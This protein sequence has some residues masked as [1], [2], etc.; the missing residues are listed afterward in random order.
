MMLVPE[1]RLGDSA[2]LCSHFVR[3]RGGAAVPLLQR[4]PWR[5]PGALDLGGAGHSGT[6]DRR[7]Q[8]D[9]DAACR[10]VHLDADRVAISSLQPNDSPP[11]AADSPELARARPGRTP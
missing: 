8:Q 7:P 4:R 5:D 6:A 10:K 2:D 9:S 11:T 1:E 3:R